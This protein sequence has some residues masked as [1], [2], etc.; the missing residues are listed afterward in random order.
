[1]TGITGCSSP[2]G[3]EPEKEGV[4]FGPL[5]RNLAFRAIALNVTGS[6]LRTLL[7]LVVFLR[8][9]VLQA[10][11]CSI[12]LGPD[13]VICAN[14]TTTLTGP[15]GFTNYLW[16]TGAVTPSI[17]VGAPAA[18]Y[19]C[20]VTYPSGNL[21]ANGNFSS[22]N[23]GFSSQFNYGSNLQIEGTYMVGSNPNSYHPQF[24][25]S[26]TGNFL[27]VNA[28]WDSYL[29]G[30]WNCWCQDVVVCPEQTYTL[31]F[32]GRSVSGST[33]ARVQWWVNGNA[34]GP[35]HSL[36]VQGAGW[37]SFNTAWT[38]GV[39]QTNATICLRV[40]SGDGPGNDFGLDDISL[41]GTIVLR[42]YIDVL[43]N[44]LPVMNCGGPYGPVCVD[45]A[46]IALNGS[47]AG[48]TWSGAGVSGNS[49]DPATAGLGLHPLTYSYTDGNGCPNTCTSTVLVNP[50]PL[51]NCGGPYGPY[52]VNG[53]AVNLGGLPAGGSWSGPGV[54]A[55]S[56][57]PASAGPGLHVV[58]YSY[59]NANG[60]TRT[61]TA[62]ITVNALPVV[63]CGT[64][65][66]FCVDAPSTALGGAPAGGTWSGTGVVANAFVPS[67]AGAGSHPVT[68]TYTDANGC[69]NTCTTNITVNALPALA[70]GSYGPVCVSALPVA[71]N[72]LPAGGTWSG[73][74]VVGN[75]FDPAIAGAGNHT[76]SY[77]YT[78]ANGCTNSCTTSITVHPLPVVACGSYGPICINGA[79][80]N[81]VGNPVGGT[82]S[83]PGVAGSAF[84]PASAGAG[85]H[86]V[87]YAY[88]DGNGCQNTCTT[89]IHV[90]PL[91]VVVCDAFG[92]FCVN[93]SPIVLTATP[94]G[95]TWSGTGVNAG[96]FDP[97][98][99]GAGVH[100]ITY[101]FS[102]ANGCTN[103]C[104]TSI[105]VNPLPVMDC[106]TY[107]PYCVNAGLAVLAGS[108]A[109]GTWSGPGVAGNNFDPSSAGVGLHALTYQ[110]TD[111][112]G[113]ANTCGTTITVSPL[114]VVDCGTYAPLCLNALPIVLGGSPAG[115][116]W[117]GSGVAGGQFN[118]AIAGAGD[119][120]ITYLYTDG[121]GCTA[122]CSTTITVYAAPVLDCGSYG[123]LCVNAVPLALSGH[124]A[125]GTWTGSGVSSDEFDP[126]VAGVG[127]HTLTYS[128][129]DANGCFGTCTTTLT[130]H[131]L[132]AVDAGSYPPVCA[133]AAPVLLAGLPAGGAWSGSGIVGTSFDP[134]SA[135]TGTHTL[136][137]SLTDANGC[138]ASDQ[139][140]MT[141]NA[142]PVAD[143]GNDTTVCAGEAVTFDAF[144]P[145]A[146]YL[147]ND[148]S[149]GPTFTTDVPQVVSVQVTSNGCTAT[150]SA[151]LI[152]FNLQ[153]VDLGA[154]LI[155]C[156]NVP[157]VLSVNVPGATYTW[158]TTA[159][160]N[161]I[162]ATSTGWYWVDAV[163]NGCSVRD[164]IYVTIVPM[165]AV[166]LG[167]AR[168]V[169]PGA[170][171]LL[172]AT[173]PNATYL[174]SNGAT[175]PS[176]NASLGIWTVEVTVDGCTTTDQV[177]VGNW[178]PPTVDLGADTTLCP[179]ETLVLDATTPFMSY[180][181]QDASSAATYTVQQAGTYSVT[182]T[183][184]HG[185][186]GTDAVVVDYATPIP[187]FIGNDTTI[188]SGTMIVLDATTPGAS[189]YSWNNG[190]NT[191][192]LPAA[193][194]LYWVDVV[195]G[196]CVVHD[197]I[198]I[199]VALPPAF[200]LGNDTT[201]CPGAT[202]L[203]DPGV[204]DVDYQWQDNSTAE[205]YLVNTAGTYTLSLTNE[206]LCSATDQIIVSYAD[207]DAVNLGP[208]TTICDGSTLV[209][210]ASLPGSTYLWNTTATT[211]TINVTL[212][213]TYTVQVM[214]AG[215]SVTDTIDVLVAP[216][217]TVA[218]GNDTT[219][220][221]NAS[222]IL[223]ATWPGA[224]YLWSTG[225][226]AP[227][228][229]V[230]GTDTY[231]VVVDLAGC[232]ASDAI[233]V[234]QLGVLSL[235]LGPDTTLC[236]GA[237]LV[238]A[239][240]LPGGTTVWSTNFVGPS[241]VVD[242]AEDYWATIT[243]DGCSVTDSI[244]V[245]YV[246]LTP[247]D[248]GPD[249]DVCE[250]DQ[251]QF[252][253]TVPGATYLWDDDSTD[254]QRS[255]G[256]AGEYWARIF[257]NGCETVDTIA[258]AIV[259][260]PSVELGPDTGLCA[261]ATI[262]LNAIQPGATYLWS[263]GSDQPEVL[264]VP[265]DWNVQVTVNGCSNSDA[266]TISELPTPVVSFPADTTLCT[267]AVWLMDAAQPNA[268]YSWH[269]A[270][271]NSGFLVDA[272]GSYGVTVSIDGCTVSDEVAVTYFDASLV[273]L[274]ADTTLC[275]GATLALQLD[276]PNVDI[277][278]PDG[279]HQPSFLVSSAGTYVV[280]VEANGCTASDGIV[281]D[282]TPLPMPDLG[283]DRI[284][285]AGDSV[286]LAI[287]P[288]AASVAWNNGNTDDSLTVSAT[289]VYTVTLSL[290]GCTA[291]DAAFVEV[292][293]VV[294]RID[295]G[296]DATICPGRTITLDA[297]TPRAQYTW[298]TGDTDPSIH[299]FNTG[300]Y[301]VSLTGP[302][303]S[304]VDTVVVTD[305]DCAPEVHVPN[306]FTPD[307]DGLNEVFVPVTT[308]EFVSYGFNVFDRW[309][310]LIFTS[311][312]P[313][314]GWDGTVDGT[315]APIGV[316]VWQLA[317]QAVSDV[318]VTQERMMG[319]VTLVR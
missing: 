123:P 138:S 234:T 143:I 35:E 44:P 174:W 285:C 291:S 20:Q 34:V 178:D 145:G 232:T 85:D 124:P 2:C 39:G 305:G 151:E 30:Q 191:T 252:D 5:V 307:G 9:V 282:Y 214:Q 146:T 192:T 87:T 204:T 171:S 24:S 194:G 120:V 106:G 311:D 244:T 196:N 153:S 89:T 58:T 152:N 102:D 277:T 251:L 118:A 280:N 284:L 96:S 179:G 140:T 108:P 154:D 78:D 319:S 315:V 28:G 101:S 267:G 206:D 303:I 126:A 141:V 168:M 112:N 167:P 292:L 314:I 105:T 54:V 36:P 38:T 263:N 203:L 273:D 205:T 25:G 27:I 84:D 132:P 233:S 115:G 222:V 219:L 298:N 289:G 4:R 235:D 80:I 150:A 258:V 6:N 116:T 100:P 228:I 185:C 133:S 238:L 164:S 201:L 43:V 90:D 243:I 254:P 182:L 71:L 109:G 42:D 75:T 213:G 37:Q 66:P 82:W 155:A 51:V 297:F 61:C 49:F 253:I 310:E 255:V 184:S 269:D 74:G 119:H 76:I 246:P 216:S 14:Q 32:R 318:G 158:N 21:V 130:V 272:P 283:D 176:V 50:L 193:G 136:T 275:P 240:S 265:G 114:P 57:T 64:Y 312:E 137:Y 209:L 208:D 19:W 128:A 92:P 286:V 31:S 186:T 104:T 99:A 207:P 229:T 125:G 17:T 98:A 302:C 8:S 279:S 142:A 160:T 56:F 199:A 33:P 173:T 262:P 170:T 12:N 225:S 72:G 93:A 157:P 169:C 46:P 15:A 55:N 83:G 110:Y 69:T 163:L 189:L 236:P 77:G 45:G 67:N 190:W 147:W 296:P 223:D 294:N 256:E 220:C 304:A 122:S 270:S 290:D 144:V 239:A 88:T 73:T 250:L 227:T 166:D 86:T 212:P 135:G 10:Q 248:L 161:S 60:C 242:A 249:A 91:P 47:P 159:T 261:G 165:P 295:L 221:G 268:T 308:G 276:L 111:V 81:L 131:P 48:G 259:P 183:D 195:Q 139:V 188:C 172:N 18:T 16:S 63:A 52:C 306:S 162:S 181:W 271:T 29:A 22:G 287:V 197:E 95:G 301:I 281:V 62:N 264:A 156:A 299:V 245:D 1:M 107:G 68:Y 237:T 7:P 317:Y 65:G 113:C 217:P 260:L 200:S 97:A 300:T 134:S 247:L 215:C 11:P 23:T 41:S 274:G 59:T 180:A 211:A 127:N 309:G 175:T 198:N 316:Y 26:G 278:W 121:N 202:L 149:V 129:V 117:S 257:L 288:G 3:Q 241:I 177:T 218:L 94:A 210:D 224:T 40:V 53:P 13:P 231:S 266:I 313:G 103:T 79:S 187:V 226:M 293:P 230:S 148:N 70:C